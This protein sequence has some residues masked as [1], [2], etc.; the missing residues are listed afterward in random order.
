MLGAD[1]AIGREIR[2]TKP[3]RSKSQEATL[4]LFRTTDL[5]RR[6]FAETLQGSGVTAQQYNV[7]RILRGAEPEGLPT[8]AIAERMLERA[9]GITRMLDRLE[10]KDWVM[11]E[12]GQEDRRC[13]H[14]RITD[15]G[16]A[17]LAELDEP[18]A[19]AEDQVLAMLTEG[20]QE[21]LVI[22]LDRIRAGHA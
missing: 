4:G 8:L 17:L 22:L 16:L 1:S 10:A 18:V 15:T 21:T 11:R 3:F 12:R 14:C 7:L 9:P 5:L 6:C 19:A 13:V 2:Q 20:E